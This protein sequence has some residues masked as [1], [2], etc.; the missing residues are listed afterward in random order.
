MP[1]PHGD[2]D[3]TEVLLCSVLSHRPSV[4]SKTEKDKCGLG[5]LIL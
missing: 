1:S 3:A 5:I 4:V 2:L